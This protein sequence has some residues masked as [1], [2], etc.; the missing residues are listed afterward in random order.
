MITA[1]RKLEFLEHKAYLLRKHSLEMTTKAGSGHA[2]SCLSAADLVAALFFYAMHYDPAH[3]DN[4]NNDR[5]I[6][7]KGHASPLLYAVWHELGM[8]S[9]ADLMAYRTFAS[10]LEGHPTFRFPYTQAATGSLGIGLSIGVGMALAAKRD[11][12]DFRTYVLMGDAEIAE[13]SVWEA[14]ELAAFYQLNNCI[15]IVDC[16]RLGQSTQSLHGH[17]IGRYADQFQAF[18]WNVLSIDGH[19]MQEILQAV[20]TARVQDAKPTVILAKTFKGHGVPLFEDKQGFHGV[21]LSAQQLPEALQQLKD[22]FPAAANYTADFIWQ[23]TKPTAVAN[24]SAKSVDAISIDKSSYK[25]SEV[26]ATRKAYGQALVALGK[27]CDTLFVLDAEVKNS[28]FAELFEQQFPERFVQCFVA[29]QNM[30]SMGVGFDLCYKIPFISTFAS[31]FTRAHDQIRMAAIGQARLRLVG[32]HAGVSI[33]QDGPSQMGLEDIA[34]MRALPQSIVLYPCDAVS[35]HALTEHMANYRSGISYMRTTRMATPVI[36]DA[37]EQFVIGGCKVVRQPANAQACII[38]AGVTLHEALKAHDLLR[39]QNIHVSV[40]DAYS[41]KPLDTNTLHKIVAASGNRFV[42]VED[43]YLQGGLGEAVVYELRN[44][45]AR[46]TCL[47]VTE[48]PR[49]GKPEELLAWAGIDAAAI[50]KA[51]HKLLK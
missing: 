33:G 28:T 1:S 48:L 30:V 20:D 37:S 15:A 49:S 29:E 40:V 2:T 4:G 16:N 36:Y 9:Y 45:D 35:T 5:F 3:I 26:I 21:P 39:E 22:F 24:P 31:F 47:A 14:A 25:K 8:V 46:S 13:G 50:V 17:A 34:L 27:T 38:A 18:G 42:T 10:A 32:S 51:V 7:S 11:K 6:L 12:K 23:P 19:N 43:H 41:V 44:S